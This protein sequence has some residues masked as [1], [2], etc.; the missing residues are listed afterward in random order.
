MGIYIK[1]VLYSYVAICYRGNCLQE[2]F[3]EFLKFLPLQRVGSIE[4]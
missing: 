1:L 2:T 3:L 4:Q